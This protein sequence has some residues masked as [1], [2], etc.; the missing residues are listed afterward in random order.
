MAPK[1]ESEK[2]RIGVQTTAFVTGSFL[3]G[4]MMSLSVIAVPV[5]LDTNLTDSGHTVHQWARLYHYGHIYMP[6]LA[7]ATTGLYIYT[8][9][10]KW[11]A[12]EHNRLL[13]YAAA[14][15][16]TIAIVPFTWVLMDPTNYILFGLDELP[17]GSTQ[18]MDEPTVRKLLMKWAWLHVVRSLLPLAGSI[19]GLVGV[20]QERI[21]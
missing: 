11:A 13:I 7:V 10:R 5:L 17:K 8:A 12:R 19:L 18:M 6:A 14:G 4:A 16:S 21:W 2:P 1:H 20:L 3:S 9:M 15:V